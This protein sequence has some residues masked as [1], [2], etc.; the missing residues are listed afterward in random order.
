M[1]VYITSEWRMAQFRAYRS[2]VIG[3]PYPHIPTCGSIITVLRYEYR[4]FFVQLLMVFSWKYQG[5][6]GPH[7]WRSRTLDIGDI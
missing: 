2:I 5:T 1:G 6:Q 7:G 4:T 3:A